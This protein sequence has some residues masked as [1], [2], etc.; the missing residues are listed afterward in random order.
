MTNWPEI[1]ETFFQLSD[2]EHEFRHIALP[3]VA[4]AAI[5]EVESKLNLSLPQELQDF[6]LVS[7]GIGL[8]SGEE[9]DEPRFIP[10]LEKLPAFVKACRA[11]FSETH[12][13]FAER[14]LPCIDWENGDSTGFLM[15]REGEYL[16][17]LF[18][19]SHEPYSYDS[20]QDV[21]DF[22]QPSAE[23]I[24]DLLTPNEES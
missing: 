14:Y 17:Q 2:P 4:K 19:F 18:T 12:P 22:L 13:I 5:G 20:A 8:A 21:N 1:I 11:S 15:D 24:A 9:P 10:S 23:G 6:Y 16:P 7:N 3:G